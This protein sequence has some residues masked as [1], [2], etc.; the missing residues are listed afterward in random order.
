MA[1]QQIQELNPLMQE[2]L[3]KKA[4]VI[5]LMPDEPAAFRIGGN[6]SGVVERGTGDVLTAKQIEEI[7]LATLGEDALKEVGIETGYTTSRYT[8][9]GVVDGQMSISKVG[10]HYTIAVLLL[11]TC[12]PDV[13][14]TRIPSSILEA[15]QEKNGLVLFSGPTGS[16]KTTSLLSALDFINQQKPCLI[17]TLEY[18]ISYQLT[19]K[20]AIIQQRQVGADVPDLL[21]GLTASLSQGPDVLMIGELRNGEEIRMCTVIS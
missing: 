20:R 18:M 5:Y 13:Q 11:P 6:V 21:T 9:P 19:P 1:I 17:C 14:S 16:G 4:S 10:G 3:D 2:A 8:L 7:A 12:L 15:A